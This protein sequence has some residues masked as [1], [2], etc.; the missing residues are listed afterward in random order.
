MAHAACP[1]DVASPFGRKP[2]ALRSSLLYVLL[3]RYNTLL[4][5]DV[6]LHLE[7]LPLLAGFFTYKAG[8]LGRS[9]LALF[10]QM[11]GKEDPIDAAVIQGA[12][13]SAAPPADIDA[14]VDRQVRTL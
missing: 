7:L 8:V 2:P 12:T 1:L 13:S 10:R 11:A 9:C 14:I 5:D 6:G 3:C 4:A